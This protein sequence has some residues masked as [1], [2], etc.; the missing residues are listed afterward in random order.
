MSTAR[1]DGHT[2]WYEGFS[3]GPMFT[4]TREAAVALVGKGPGRCLDL[5]CGTGLALPLLSAAGW[6]VVGTDV[7]TD[8]LAVAR[9]RATDVVQADAHDLPFDDGA[10]DAVV[11]IFTHTDFDD[12]ARVFA[13][14]HRVL[15]HGGV[16]AYA[17]VHPC[18]ASPFVEHRDDGP[19]LV[20]PGYR[21]DVWNLVSR[22]PDVPGIS[23]RVGFHHLPLA[24]LLNAVLGSGLVLTHAVE[25]GEGDPPLSFGF[26][27]E[28]R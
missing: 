6:T 12:A 21:Q 17:G 4:A 10:F 14:V 11:S 27:A 24:S 1:Y 23:S 7:S 2:E 9:T 15:R 20:H 19:W 13:E 16:F 26:R 3:S 28:K 25:P 5:G 8:Q 22:N 18:F